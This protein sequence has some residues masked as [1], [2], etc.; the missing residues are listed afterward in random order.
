MLLRKLLV[1][2]LG[3]TSNLP[4]L[5]CNS[6]NSGLLKHH[7][8]RPKYVQTDNPFDVRSTQFPVIPPE[9]S[10]KTRRASEWVSSSIPFQSI[11]QSA[12]TRQPEIDLFTCRRR[13]SIY[14]HCPHD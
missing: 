12:K 10:V 4:N 1:P 8:K 7:C 2:N 14:D 9:S 11:G 3:S 6:P 13:Q 5:G